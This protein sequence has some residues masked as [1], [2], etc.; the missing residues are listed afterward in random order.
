M[1]G[2]RC[3][4]LRSVVVAGGVQGVEGGC[5]LGNLDRL[6]SRGRPSDGVGGGTRT[7]LATETTESM[8]M[9]WVARRIRPHSLMGKLVICGS[10]L[11]SS[12]NFPQNPNK[13]VAATARRLHRSS[14]SSR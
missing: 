5:N 8:P 13:A 6:A 10:H 7:T 2:A 4:R 12:R 14:P 9:I 1:T 3:G 11:K